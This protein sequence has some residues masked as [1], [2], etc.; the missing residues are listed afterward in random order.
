M[1]IM[2]INYWSQLSFQASESS[3]KCVREDIYEYRYIVISSTKSFG[4]LLHYIK[5]LNNIFIFP[6][7]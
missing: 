3:I 1:T 6:Y 7:L 5:T 2:Q 4:T